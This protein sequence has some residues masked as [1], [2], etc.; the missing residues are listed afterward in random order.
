M[1]C[2][3]HLG[4]SHP[5][6]G[7]YLLAVAL[8]CTQFYFLNTEFHPDFIFSWNFHFSWPLEQQ[9]LCRCGTNVRGRHK[10][11]LGS[12]VQ[13]EPAWW[14]GF[15]S[16]SSPL[17]LDGFLPAERV[18]APAYVVQHFAACSE[19]AERFICRKGFWNLGLNPTTWPQ[20]PFGWEWRGLSTQ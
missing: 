9:L 15:P 6:H 11:V 4:I 1:T 20:G 18:C 17:S 7:N 13:W 8:F 19:W 3:D 10:E 12:P 16:S 2:F 14:Q 5:L